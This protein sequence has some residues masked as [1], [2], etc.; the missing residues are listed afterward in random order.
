MPRKDRTIKYTDRDFDSIKESLVN[1]AQRYYPDTFR[2]FG[3]AGFGAL[4]TD[5]VAYIGDI[6]SFYLDYQAN[7]TYLD[8][9]IEFDNI[10]KIAKTLGY[11]FS[12]DYTSQGLVSFYATI[13]ASLTNETSLDSDY[14]PV[15]K[16][17]AA[18]ATDDGS[19]FILSEDVNFADP[20]NQ[21]EVAVVDDSTGRV[22]HYAVRAIGK[23]ISGEMVTA[24]LEVEAF[25]RFKKVEILDDFITEIIS[26]IDSDGNEYFEVDHLSQNVIYESVK[27]SDAPN[28]KVESLMKP[29]LVTRRFEVEKREDSTI[30]QFGYGSDKNLTSDTFGRPENVAIQ[31]FGRPYVSST[32]F[33]PT[34]LIENDKFGIA[35]ANTTLTVKYLKNS[36]L[37]PNASKGEINIITDSRLVFPGTGNTAITEEAVQ[38]SLAVAN[39]EPIVGSVAIPDSDEIRTRAVSFIASQKR[40]VTKQDYESLCYS[41][42]SNFGAVK[43]VRALQ[44]KDSFKKNLNL[45]VISENSLGQFTET[46]TTIK[47]NLKTWITRHKMITDT[48]D[49]LDAKVINL[50]VNFTVVADVDRNKF[51]VLAA[52]IESLA[53]FFDVKFDIGEPLFFNDIFRE[54][55]DVDGVLDVTEVFCKSLSGGDYSSSQFTIADNLS[56][57]GRSL[58]QQEDQVFEIKFFDKDLIG[59]VL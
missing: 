54:L 16:K 47:E 2:D 31:K 4:M 56:V 53:R 14:A 25:E 23:V 59:T 19:R 50:S 29:K 41:M 34:N 9:A 1:Y 40:A 18:L 55:K 45:Y 46:N 38:Q 39:E 52:C 24:D 28:D 26:V 49:I 11:K 5:Y 57:D 42:P 32:T 21:R 6:L 15:L 20:D 30:L 35:P 51:D 8:T 37:N 13:P 10:I 3:E 17:G 27:N 48:V 22:T 43:R 33:D 7:E 36:S 58:L 44:D 12:Y